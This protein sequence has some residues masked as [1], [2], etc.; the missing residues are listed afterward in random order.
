MSNQVALD[1]LRAICR[2]PPASDCPDALDA[3]S[4]LELQA[5]AERELREGRNAHLQ[6]GVG[7]VP[8]LRAADNPA[9]FRVSAGS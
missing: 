1:K 4:S 6:R 2:L 8:P 3:L 9:L 5:V 7:G